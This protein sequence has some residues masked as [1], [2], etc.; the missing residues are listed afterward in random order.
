MSS[1]INFFVYWSDP[2]VEKTRKHKIIDILVITIVAVLRGCDDL[3]EI[4]LY[5]DS[6]EEWLKIF[7]EL[8]KEHLL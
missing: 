7:L 5:G 1:F 4:E 8:P 3:N 6:K 2:R